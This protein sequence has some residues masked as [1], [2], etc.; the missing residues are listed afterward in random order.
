MSSLGKRERVLRALSGEEV[1]KRPFTFWHPFGLSHMK[2]ESLSTVGISF[3]AAYGV[4]LLRFPSVKDLPV[5][6]QTSLDRPHD[7]TTLE[8]VAAHSGFWAERIEGLRTT[9]KLAE[10]RIA[11][12]ET[13]PDPMTALSWICPP[14]VL[15]V[16]ERSH[17][18]YLEKA[19][20]AV[21][22]SLRNYVRSLATESKVDGLV[23]EVAS[24]SYE[25][26]EPSDFTS[27]VKP[28]LS[29][30]VEE[31]RTH[32]EVPIWIQLQ[33]RR[34]YAEPL[35]DLEPSLLSWSHLA[36]G[37]GL[38]KLPKKQRIR[39]AGGLDESALVRA[40][41]QEIRRQVEEARDMPVALLCPGDA[42]P[43]DLAPS[44]LQALSNFLKKR[45]RLPETAPTGGRPERVI[46]EP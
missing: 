39:V 40:S 24:A 21:T 1:D 43:A 29:Q 36:H 20:G 6:P 23:I 30:L 32:S 15:S 46:D 4:D 25:A 10:G 8:P 12:F 38:D 17:P 9:V 16:A 19:L 45:D 34:T 18:S 3:A 41:Y 5:A 7:L 27:L 35:F 13:V 26:R 2:A 22:E 37:P 31:I 33:G 42:L 44:R 14:E 28:H 11:V